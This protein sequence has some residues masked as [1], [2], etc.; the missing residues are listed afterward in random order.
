MIVESYSSKMDELFSVQTV[1]LYMICN[2]CVF[3]IHFYMKLISKIK[4]VLQFLLNLE[5]IQRPSIKLHLILHTFIQL[6]SELLCLQYFLT[7]LYQ[8]HLLPFLHMLFVQ[9]LSGR[10]IPIICEEIWSLYIT[11]AV[12]IAE[13]IASSSALVCNVLDFT[14]CTEVA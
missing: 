9:C 11:D 5:L 13:G 4:Y 14:A 8:P 2:F 12:Y 3:S 1:F 10:G 7:Q 6:K